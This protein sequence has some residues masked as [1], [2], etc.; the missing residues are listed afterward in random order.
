MADASTI[1]RGKYDRLAPVFDLLESLCEKMIFHAWR[2][3]LWKDV[4]SGRILEVGVGTGK[5]FPYHPAGAEITAID[6]SPEMLKR[7]RNRLPR[8]QAAVELE[9]M[10]VERLA[11]A[12]NSFDTVVASFVFCSVPHPVRGLREVLRVCK[13]EGKIMLLEH[14]VSE[15]PWQARLMEWLNPVILGLAGANINRRTVRNAQTAGLIIERVE[16]LGHGG[17][18][19][20]IEARK[21]DGYNHAFQPTVKD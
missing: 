7:A 16:D 14:V 11:F 13:P 17:L 18:V 6:F 1:I 10:D 3:R 12:D 2:R 19:K 8:S 9:E 15:I 5:N 21:P 4:A 20:L